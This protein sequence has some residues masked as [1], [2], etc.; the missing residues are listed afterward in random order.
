MGAAKV[1]SGSDNQPLLGA[2]QSI[3]SANATK[4]E[5]AE[6]PADLTVPKNKHRKWQPRPQYFGF[7]EVLTELQS[8]M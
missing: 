6:S 3:T 1:R 8:I 5:E 4:P 7:S 2:E